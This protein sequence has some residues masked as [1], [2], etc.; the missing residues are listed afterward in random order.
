MPTREKLP[1]SQPEKRRKPSGG[2]GW[3]RIARWT[4][5][6]AIWTAV[7]L[8]LVLAWYAWDLP[9]VSELGGQARRPSVL[10][11]AADGNVI[12]TY[13]DYYAG[14]AQV[15]DLPPYVM[16]AILATEDR[17]FFDHIGF[18][19]IGIVRAMVINIRAGSLRQG[20]ST[21]TQQLAKNLFLSNE[22]TLR[23]KVQETLLAL[24]LEN[25]FTK[26]QIF[27]IYLN[28]VYFGA[29]AWGIE[30]A[31]R[32]YF[33][34]PA[35][36][37]NMRETALIAGLLKAPSKL[38]P[39]RDRDAAETRAS[40]V[41]ENMVAAG[42][43]N[44]ADAAR[45]DKAPL[46]LVPGLANVNTRYFTDWAL[47]E[48]YDRVGKSSRDLVVATTLDAHLQEIAEV[49]L[50]TVVEREETRRNIGQGALV[51]LS[52]QGAVLAMVGGRDYGE[53]QF[54]RATQAKRQPG[55]A[56]KPFV[57]LAALEAGIQPSD[58]MVDGPINIGGW[59][60][61]NFDEKFRGPIAVRDALALSI[62]TVA[63]QLSERVGRERVAQA[64]RRLGIT[65]PLQATPSIALGASEVTL[66]DLTT[67]YATIGN[68]GRAAMPHAVTE[69][70][71]SDGNI[72][73][74]R[75]GSGAQQAID[76]HTAN[77]LIEMMGG[78]ISYGTGRSAA[79]PRP[80]AGKTGTTSD[81][82]DAWFV[83]FA[84]DIVAGVWVGNDNT[85]PMKSVTG[86]TVPAEI[87]RKFMVNALANRPYRPPEIPRVMEVARP[88]ATMPQIDIRKLPPPRT[89]GPE[90]RSRFLDQPIRD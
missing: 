18:D 88:P 25:K 60:P 64:A 17:R 23:R 53:S 42:Y 82:R 84:S 33:G 71:D 28:R 83:G 40:Q 59:R 37:L 24:W 36:D 87:W 70:R 2:S 58:T 56:F 90:Q 54:N 10:I 27:A 15:Q 66:L 39:A 12:A 67:A 49:S 85:A 51:A 11:T 16:Q 34:R 65:T 6:A 55:S 73:Y 57:Y 68:F 48:V 38:S 4:T 41:I 43:L 74:R 77:V 79:L 69:I 75:T 52:P 47:E 72:L 76:P 3:G 30:A 44:E 5:I 78:V 86:G 31:A 19:P 8:G 45:A 14:P 7:G 50:E 35:R 61:A 89:P 21:L 13:G 22:R 63:V 80:A 9:D 1:T 32:R 46:R 29:G 20:G 26:Q 81:Y 62:N